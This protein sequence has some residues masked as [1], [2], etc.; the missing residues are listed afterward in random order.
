MVEIPHKF[1]LAPPLVE[2]EPPLWHPFLSPDER[3]R[4]MPPAAS[5]SSAPRRRARSAADHAKHVVQIKDSDVESSRPLPEIKVKTLRG[6][7]LTV[8]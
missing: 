5:S 1:P 2:V 3:M 4:G 8:N 6:R 7:T